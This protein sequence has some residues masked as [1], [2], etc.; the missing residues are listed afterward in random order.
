MDQYLYPWYKKDVSEGKITRQ[1]AAELLG[2]LWLKLRDNDYLQTLS[3]KEWAVMGM[4]NANVTLGG[5][6]KEGR[7]S[8]NELSWLILEVMRQM[9]LSEPAV[10]IRYNDGMSKEFL[11]HA[12]E[13]NRD[14]EGGNPSF[15]N[16]ELGI[17]RYLDRGI[18]LED[19]VEWVA[20]GCLGVNMAGVDIHTGG[21]QHLNQAKIFEITLYDGFDPRMGKQLGPK[22]G[23]VTKFTSIEQF[24]EAFFK[25]MDYFAGQ[26]RKHWFITRGLKGIIGESTDNSGLAC[27]MLEDCITKGLGPKEGGGRYPVN[28]I[29]WIGDRGITDVADCLVAI[30]YLVF[31]KKKLTMAELMEAMKVNWEEKEYIHQAC[32]KAPKYGNDDD[33]VDDIFNYVSLK[34][35]EI[36]LK[37]DPFTGLKPF[38]FKGA[39]GGHVIHGQVVGALPNGRK[40]GTPVNDGG[41][42]PMAGMDVKGPTAVI[43]SA[44]KV[45]HAWN[46]MG[47]VH[48]MKFDKALLNTPEK[49]EK[50][51]TLIK[52]FMDRGGWHIQ[53][54]IVNPQDLIDARK[55]PEK[56]ANLI[57]RV[58]GFSAYFVDLP[59]AVQDEIIART[60]HEA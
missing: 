18:R 43:N 34:S 37:P 12:L 42:S 20:S 1:E 38:L 50:L 24:Y 48:N 45:N 46:A 10:Y 39:G 4:I 6:T 55:H 30:K 40:A 27:A 36:L 32:L 31:D 29:E 16:D 56:W 7:D 41:T 58:A 33:Y 47:I 19:A 44:T 9:K 26:M 35:Q 17:N 15:L 11:I 52:T 3:A 57:V 51:L 22:T 14:F 8:T 59:Y 23:D 2:C 25:Q 54:N 53:F 28:S 49:L 5:R 21:S 13:C 60:L